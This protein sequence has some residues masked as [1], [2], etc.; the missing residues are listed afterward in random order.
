MLKFYPKLKEL[1][2]WLILQIIEVIAQ[3]DV[4]EEFCIGSITLSAIP[5]K[6]TLFKPKLCAEETTNIAAFA[7]AQR[8]AP[9][10]AMFAHGQSYPND[11][12]KQQQIWE[13][14]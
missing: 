13:E 4:I 3:W 1:E 7:S 2:N 11:H 12:D 10:I 6:I 9:L 5:S 8:G 14:F